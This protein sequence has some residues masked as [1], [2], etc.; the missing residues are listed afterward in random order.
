MRATSSPLSP[1]PLVVEK[2]CMTLS[3]LYLGKYG[4]I[5]YYLEGQGDSVKGLIMGISR[6]TMWVMGVISLL[7]KSS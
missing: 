4:I 2:S 3:T 7:T 5:V 1:N 6:V